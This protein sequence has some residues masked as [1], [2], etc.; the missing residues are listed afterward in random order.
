MKYF[1]LTILMVI[2]LIV[3]SLVLVGCKLE[4]RP[5]LQE[6]Q[7]EQE[8]VEPIKPIKPVEPV[9]PV[10]EDESTEV[11]IVQV[12]EPLPEQVKEEV[13][14]TESVKIVNYEERKVQDLLDRHKKINSYSFYYSTSENWNLLRDKYFVKGNK[15]K[16][17]LFEPKMWDRETY[18]DTVYLDVATQNGFGYCESREKERCG[19]G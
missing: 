3:C 7:V 10:F 11:N 13:Q 17:K 12:R 5:D 4:R 2:L 15:I 1:K 19:A 18:F 6:K 9:E 8:L 14:Q 16:I